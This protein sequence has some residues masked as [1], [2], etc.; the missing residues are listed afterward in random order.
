MD[1]NRVEKSNKAEQDEVGSGRKW[2]YAILLFCAIFFLGSIGALIYMFMEFTGCSTNNAFISLTLIFCI[3]LPSAQLTGNEGNMLSVSC[4]SAWAVFLCYTAVIKNPDTTCNPKA[5]ESSPISI[6]YGLI[7]TLI[8]LSW[9]G[10]SYTAKDKLTDNKNSDDGDDAT[11]D[12]KDKT[13]ESGTRTKREVTGVVVAPTASE[14]SAPDENYIPVDNHQNSAD[15][16]GA[17]PTKSSNAWKLNVALAVVSC[18]CAMT[19]TQWGVVEANDGTIAHRNVG[20]IS[21]WVIIGSQW[22]VMTLYLWTLIAPRL[23]PNRDFS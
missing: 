16:R 23:F 7:L 17:E 10:W 13:P 21:M 15:N 14:T 5:G 20:H 6:A 19:L 22:F 1:Y 2:L 4:I 12:T 11:P 8:S 18:W 3:V 9:T